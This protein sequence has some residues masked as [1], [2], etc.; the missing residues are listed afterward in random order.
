MELPT[1]E[2]PQLATVSDAAK[3]KTDQP[4]FANAE[5][6]DKVLIYQTAKK[7]ILYRPTTNKIIEVGPVTLDNTT[8][9]VPTPTPTLTRNSN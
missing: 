4:F 7:A 9:T 2:E 5:N 1:G 8:S 3:L 6:G